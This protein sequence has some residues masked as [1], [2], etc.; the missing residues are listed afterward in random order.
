M[1][2]VEAIGRKCGNL[3]VQCIYTRAHRISSLDVRIEHDNMTGLHLPSQFRHTIITQ[4]GFFSFA[5]NQPDDS[6]IVVP[7]ETWCRGCGAGGRQ[8]TVSNRWQAWLLPKQRRGGGGGGGDDNFFSLCERRKF[9]A[10][11]GISFDSNDHFLSEN[12]FVF[13]A[14][15]V[16]HYSLHSPKCFTL[17]QNK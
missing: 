17:T 1:L 5:H 15:K 9:V 10:L 2:V 7:N 13:G 11:C 16:S 8:P 6:M 3:E 4:R 12:K 14:P